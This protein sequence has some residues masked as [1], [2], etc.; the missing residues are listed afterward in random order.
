MRKEAAF[1]SD[2]KSLQSENNALREKLTSTERHVKILQEKLRQLDVDREKELVDH[3]KVVSEMQSRY[4]KEHQSFEAATKESNVL[5][6]QIQQKDETINQLKTR[7]AQLTN[8]VASLSKEVKELT[9]KVYHVP[10][11][12]ILRDELANLKVD[13]AR[14]LSD[15]VVKAKQKTQQEEQIRNLKKI[16][17]LEDQNLD[18]LKKIARSEEARTEAYDAYLAVEDE[19]AALAAELAELR[20]AREYEDT[21]DVIDRLQVAIVEVRKLEPEFDIA[22]LVGPDPEKIRLQ[23]MCADLQEELEQCKGKLEALSAANTHF[24][25]DSDSSKKETIRHVAEQFQNKIQKLMAVHAK[26]RAMHEKATRDLHA[27]IS[28]LEQ[29]EGR[30]IVDMRREMNSRISEMETEMQKQRTRTLDVIAEKERELEAARSVLVS[31]RSEQLNNAPA[32]PAQAGKVTLSKRRSSEYKRYL[33]RKYSSGKRYLELTRRLFIEHLRALS[34]TCFMLAL[35][36]KSK[37]DREGFPIPAPNES[38]NIFYEEELLKKDREIQEMRNIS[39]QLDYRLREV[40]QASLVKELEHHKKAEAMSEEITKLQNKLSLLSSGGE[41]E[42][43]RNIFVQ[44]IQSG[45]A[46]AKKNI[47]KAM[48]M[49]LKLSTNEMKAID[50]K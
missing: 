22:A 3:G 27:R 44:F 4:A 38:R 12:Q 32:D 30:L 2:K 39:H 31:I 19:K 11:I 5:V 13:H 40:E 47:L 16:A 26:D 28:E 24:P 23:Q 50:S 14:E 34:I 17:D 41:T 1:Q 42:Y 9:D 29:R 18:L 25:T 15:A 6:K 37:C 45:D 33:E 8:Q 46:S 10:S 36:Y 20:M 49:A 48:G 35:F 43:L 7:E 21:S